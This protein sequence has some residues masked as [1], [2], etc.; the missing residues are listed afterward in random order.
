MVV[1][2]F[3]FRKF[4]STLRSKWFVN[5][6]GRQDKKFLSIILHVIITAVSVLH[7]MFRIFIFML[8]LDAQGVMPE[9]CHYYAPL[10]L[11][12]KDNISVNTYFI[13]A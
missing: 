11:H 8:M 13:K 6:V 9:R 12:E 4:F 5:L 3:S 7:I 2:C 1:F 10:Y